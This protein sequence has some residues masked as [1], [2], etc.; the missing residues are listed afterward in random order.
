MFTMF[1]ISTPQMNSML[2]FGIF[3]WFLVY[4]LY[5]NVNVV[6][7]A[8]LFKQREDENKTQYQSIYY[9]RKKI[10]R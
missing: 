2:E 3:V 9:E 1:E 6:A 8:N 5:T 7:L 10:N 4:S